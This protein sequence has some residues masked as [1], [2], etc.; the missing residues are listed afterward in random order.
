MHNNFNKLAA[1]IMIAAP[2]GI[3]AIAPMSAHAG[4][5]LVQNGDF[6]LGNTGFTSGY[7]YYPNG[8]SNDGSGH[9]FYQ[10]G[11]DA[12]NDNNRWVALGDHTTGSGNYMYVDGS[13][14]ANTPIWGQSIGVETGKTYEISGYFSSL[15]NASDPTIKYTIGGSDATSAF[16]LNAPGTWQ[17]HSFLWT[18]T[19]NTL[20][21]ALVDTNLNA[22]GNDF[23]IDDLSVKAVP[24]ASTVVLFSLMAIGGILI[25]RKRGSNTIA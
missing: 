25:L 16:D 10:I 13:T 6:E 20:N 1:A 3:G 18:A 7:A 22:G 23:A 14:T 2:F 9:D 15:Y 12:R 21:L 19:S 17:Q 5:N 4:A 24:E 11:T 8:S